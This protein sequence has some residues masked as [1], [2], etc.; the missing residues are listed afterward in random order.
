MRIRQLVAITVIV[1]A[2]ALC[3]GS[4][5]AQTP[6]T[7]QIVGTVTDPTGALVVGAKVTL[8]SNAGVNR[9]V[10]TGT[11]GRYTLPLLEPGSYQI[12][13][14]QSGFTAAKVVGVVVRITETTVADVALQV[15]SQATTVSVTGESPLVQTESSA[16]GTVID[17]Q[18]IRDLPLPT[19]NFQQLLTLTTGTSGPLTNSSSLGRGDVALYVNGQRALSNDVIIN[20][21]DANSIGT[22]ENPNLAVPAIDSLQEFIVQTSMYDASSG[23]NAGGNIAAVTKSAQ[24]VS[25]AAS[26]NSCAIRFWM[27]TTSSLMATSTAAARRSYAATGLQPQPVWRHAGRSAHQGSRLVL[28]LLSGHA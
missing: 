24:T 2:F 10:V 5:Y 17:E 23:R 8:T 14:E 1:G 27:R 19:N 9:Q 11:N 13:V 12:Q 4:A 21:V 28:Y 26:M 7:G 20:G 15:G 6:T 16:R 18:Q 3:A 22:G 25:M